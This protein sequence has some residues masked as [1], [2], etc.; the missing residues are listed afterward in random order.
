MNKKTAIELKEITKT[1]GTVIANNKVNI[2]VKQGEILAL[3]GENGSGKTTIMNML[4]GIYR[5]DSGSIFVK[6]QEVVI[7]SPE[8]SAKLG[9]G[10]IHQ[11]FKLVDVLTATDNIILG[12]KEKGMWLSKSRFQRIGEISQT[13]GLEI[14]PQKYVYNMSVSEK[15][16]VEILKVLYR[17][18]DI[19]ILDEPTAV[20]TP[21]EITGLFDIL[22]RMRDNGCA[23]IIITHKLNEVLEI[24]DRVTI[25]RKGESVAT[26]NT[27]E[28]NAKELTELMVGRAIE[29]AIEHPENDFEENLLEIHHLTVENQEGIE[30]LKDISFQLNQ[31]EILGVAGI[32]GSGQKELCEALA[33]LIPVK[34]GAVLYRN[35]NIV[36]MNPH[37]IIKLGISMSFIPEDRL[38]MGLVAS[39]GMV[40]NMLLKNYRHSKKGPFISKRAAKELAKKLVDDMQIV[41]PSVETPVRR[42][43]GGNVQKVLLGREIESNPNVLITAYAVRGLDIN[44][45]YAIYDALNEQKQ[46]GV[47]I[48]FIGE[49]LDVMLELCDRIMVL[50]HGRITGIVDTKSATKEEIGLMMADVV[51]D[52]E[53][54]KYEQYCG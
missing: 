11:H 13:F 24:S 45:S 39:M 17:N 49:D 12:S 9:I 30:S 44:S 32:A 27:K 53:E 20:L 1:F 23:V 28:T 43:S 47:G 54:K 7:N 34:K 16:T 42:L 4:S 33:G 29:L 46:K 40:E 10:M 35:E 38:G 25:L 15:Q 2:S 8:D 36:G 18:A 41:T 31:G 14:D 21:Q 48:L 51:L 19:L 37:D 26:V 22:R 5:P 6:G 3:L 50:C 52:K